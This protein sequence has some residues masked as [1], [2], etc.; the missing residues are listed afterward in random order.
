[1]KTDN[2][3]ARRHCLAVLAIVEGAQNDFCCPLPNFPT[4]DRHRREPRM[5]A[6]SDLEVAKS[7]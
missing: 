2:R 4:I 3:A 5:R 6:P 7:N 1:M